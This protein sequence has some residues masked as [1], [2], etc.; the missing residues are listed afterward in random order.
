MGMR[1]VMVERMH[2]P[3]RQQASARGRYILQLTYKHP[4]SQQRVP[5]RATPSSSDHVWARLSEKVP[6]SLTP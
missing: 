2:T 1:A 6:L 4:T 3:E 5:Q